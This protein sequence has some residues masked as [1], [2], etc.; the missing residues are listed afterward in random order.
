MKTDRHVDVQIDMY[1]Y[2]QTCR[3]KDIQTDRQTDKQTDRQIDRYIFKCETTKKLTNF[4]P[5]K[6]N[7]IEFFEL[8]LK[9]EKKDLN[10]L[11]C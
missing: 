9:Q 8:C 11:H 1:T 2:R 3:Q 4:F 7:K 10:K 5:E 6:L